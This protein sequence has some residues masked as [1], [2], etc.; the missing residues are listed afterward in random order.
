[1]KL[2]KKIIKILLIAVSLLVILFA[3]AVL[4]GLY[5]EW[6]FAPK[7]FLFYEH[8]KISQVISPYIMGFPIGLLGYWALIKFKITTPKKTEENEETL[9]IWNRLGKWRI[10]AVLVWVIGAYCCFFDITFVT[11]D[12]IIVHTP[13]NPKGT[14]YQY[15]DV[16]TI[17]TGFGDK[18]FSIYTHNEKGSFFYIIKLHGK[19]VVF[20]APTPNTAIERYSEDSYLE[21]EDFDNALVELGIEKESSR[22]GYQHCYYEKEYVDRF[23]RIIDRK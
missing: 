22:K 1:M 23:L 4:I 8:G 15:S 10:L 20:S 19:E 5:I 3:S 14:E 21:L 12:K 11:E 2:F 6:E 17:K 9:F 16:E 13:L 7:G 18:T